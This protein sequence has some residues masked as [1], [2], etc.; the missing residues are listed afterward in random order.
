MIKRNHK[1]LVSGY[2][3]QS[4]TWQSFCEE[5]LKKGCKLL[6]H[7]KK[8]N[9]TFNS[10]PNWKGK[11]KKKISKNFW[12]CYSWKP[13]GK[14][15]NKE[16]CFWL[17]EGCHISPACGRACSISRH[18]K[19]EPWLILQSGEVLVIQLDGISFRSS[20]ELKKYIFHLV[21]CDET[22]PG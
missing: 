22:A 21:L 2:T 18:S 14:L 8:F 11:G 7:V 20:T 12:S 15:E 9:D 3:W 5:V 13:R 1:K 6:S 17:L 19:G 16:T 10:S 4:L